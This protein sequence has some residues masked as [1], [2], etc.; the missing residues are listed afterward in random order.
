MEPMKAAFEVPR[1]D[2]DSAHQILKAFGTWQ[3]ETTEVLVCGSRGTEEFLHSVPAFGP[4]FRLHTYARATHGSDPPSEVTSSLHFGSSKGTDALQ[5]PL[6]CS[7][8]LRSHRIVQQKH[9]VVSVQNISTAFTSHPSH[10]QDR[11][12]QELRLRRP[13]LR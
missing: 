10:D 2:I 6:D 9:R 5:F 7:S 8:S 12:N 4:C 13:E 1:D 3:S 11:A